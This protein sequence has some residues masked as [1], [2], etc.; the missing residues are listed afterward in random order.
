MECKISGWTEFWREAANFS[1]SFREQMSDQLFLTFYEILGIKDKSEMRF[2]LQV[3]LKDMKT[4]VQGEYAFALVTVISPTAFAKTIT[5]YWKKRNGEDP[6]TAMDDHSL[7]RSTIEFGWCS[8]FDK[9]YFLNFIKPKKQLAREKNNLNFA[10]EYDYT[11][12]PDLSITIYAKQVLNEENLN[13]IHAV[14]SQNISDT[15]ISE[16]TSE[17]DQYHAI[18]DFQ[19]NPYEKGTA[20]LL[21]AFQELSKL[22]ISFAIERI[23]I[24]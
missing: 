14:L 10:V 17:G 23:S 22:E 19:N 13:I 7:S 16:I 5:I 2:M 12:Y 8:D 6:L 20:E 3:G 1:K 9:S 21:V 24:E 18:F 11:L 15:Y 4:V